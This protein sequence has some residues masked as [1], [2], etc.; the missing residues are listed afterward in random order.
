MH[1]L[2]VLGGLLGYHYATTSLLRYYLRI[3]LEDYSCA[4]VLGVSVTILKILSDH[5]TI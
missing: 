4:S 1:V 3:L 2:N 5:F